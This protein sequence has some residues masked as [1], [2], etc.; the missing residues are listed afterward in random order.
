MTSKLKSQ[1]SISRFFL[2]QKREEQNKTPQQPIDSENGAKDP[3]G[4]K[5]TAEI[6]PQTVKRFRSTPKT[7]Q[8]TENH[9]QIIEIDNDD[10]ENG[11]KSIDLP[12]EAPE[13]TKNITKRTNN[14]PK[15]TPKPKIKPSTAL[16]DP[17]D[18]SPGPENALDEPKPP[19]SRKSAPKT[20]KGRPKLTPLEQQYTALKSQHHDKVLAIQV[21]YKFKFFGEDAVI[22]SQLL[23][24]MLLPGNL[25]LHETTHDRFAY[26]LIPDN[27]LHIHLQR[28]LNHGLKVGVVKQTETAAIKSFEGS[29]SGVFERQ[30]T[31]VYTKA[32]YMGDEVATGDAKVADSGG[33]AEYIMC[34]DELDYS[35]NNHISIMAVQPSTGDII[36]DTFRDSLSREETETRLAYLNP[37]EVLIIG[38]GSSKETHR[39]IKVIN[40]HASV[41]DREAQKP[42]VYSQNIHDFFEDKY[43]HLADYYDD[44]LRS[45]L[46][47]VSELISYL[48][49]FKLSY[50]FTIP[51]NISAFGNS[52]KFMVLPSTTLQA[53]E[54]FRNQTDPQDSKGTLL[55]LLDHA[56]TKMGSRLLRKWI[57]KPLVSRSDIEERHQAI[58]D[59]TTNFHHIIDS[60]KNHLTAMGKSSL[61]LER[62]LIKTHYLAA[63][64]MEK[65]TRKEIYLMLKNFDDLL[66]LVGSFG[67][68][69]VESLGAKSALLQQ[70][71]DDLLSAA[72]SD[73]ATNLLKMISPTAALNDSNPQEQRNAFFNLE[74][75]DW[76]PISEQMAEIKA[77]EDALDV[78]L[79]KI[80]TLLQRPQL[81]YI[82]V[83]K[84]THL[85][86]VRNGK[87]V[88][89]LPRDW[90]KIGATK[91]V[92]RFRPPEV[93]VLH[94]KLQYHTDLLARNCD[95][96]FHQFLTDVDAQYEFFSK[97]IRSISKFDCILSLAAAS[98]V[99]SNY[100]RPLFS[101]EQVINFTNS[102]NPIIETLPH[103]SNYVANDVSM[104]QEKDRVLII[105]GPN[106]GG[107]SSY[108]KQV[109]LLVIMAQIGCFVPC[110]KAEVGI[111]DSVFI[112]MGASDNILKGKS[113]FMVEMLESST[114]I[115]NLTNRSLVI[116]DE[117]GRG[118]G[119]NDGIALAYAI[120]NYMIEEARKPLTLFITHY[121]SLHTLEDE[122]P[123]VVSNRH[124]GF[125]EKKV[126]NDWPE[127]IF[128]YTLKNG[129]VSNLYGLNVAKLAGIPSHVILEAYAVSEK[130]KT[131]IE[132]PKIEKFVELARNI[133]NG[134]DIGFED[135]MVVLENQ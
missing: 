64:D 44:N 129:V 29:K 14:T 77:I 27:R 49:E 94:K 4:P 8:K 117:I 102:R 125:V 48:S 105:T 87:A 116:L 76:A 37:S 121:P 59:V 32:T 1:P 72:E 104:A 91:T 79:K 19:S 100:V 80:R 115:Q 13:T 70:I 39:L 38:N 16:S 107:K 18:P 108:V 96:C 26:C 82:T 3:S 75:N 132:G 126:E 36:H 7:P 97:T 67:R 101:D 66:K 47:C 89:S 6:A 84:D 15:R 50:V 83:L 9:R 41:M 30:I 46:G 131:E 114:I 58:S 90:S 40:G 60:L 85:I 112:R 122:H 99:N 12:S 2:P 71:L 34:I 110:D 92:S 63:Y 124:M 10:L 33:S 111:F 57:G 78:E 134:K 61:D 74:Y 68:K 21:G 5:R 25:K 24:I 118:T 69:G 35:T 52:N 43:P 55:W 53:L 20:V 65:I 98:S 120:L 22:A 88:D 119:T 95:L 109:A 28:L 93:T 51:T 128:L 106:M 81:N 42:D 133:H 130:M 86:E 11:P 54:I 23:N 123:V 103:A 135:V 31:G 62:L 113:T 17:L 45:V 127:I 73:V 56:H